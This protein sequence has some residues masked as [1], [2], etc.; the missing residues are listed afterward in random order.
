[1]IRCHEHE[2][3][4]YGTSAAKV[5]VTA[6][7]RGGRD[8][9]R[10]FK[11]GCQ[12]FITKPID[13]TK[14]LDTSRKL[15]VLD[16]HEGTNQRRA[17]RFRDDVTRVLVETEAAGRQPAVVFD[18]SRTGIGPLLEDVSS[19]RPDQEVKIRYRGSPMAALVR[20]IQPEAQDGRHRVGFQWK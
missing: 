16:R 12:A 10:A 4:I 20:N 8:E 13:H 3:G 18:E 14:L 11:A 2:R 19:L 5:I 9:T 1:M 7:A 6:V 17:T 15:G